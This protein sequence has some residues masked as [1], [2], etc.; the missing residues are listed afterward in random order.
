MPVYHKH[1]QLLTPYKLMRYRNGDPRA[2]IDH[3]KRKHD[4]SK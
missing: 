4:Q 1:L 3:E 2:L